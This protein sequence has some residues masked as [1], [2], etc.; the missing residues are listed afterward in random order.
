M[1]IERLELDH[2]E[3]DVDADLLE[4]LLQKL[5]H[6]QRQHL[7]GAA[8]CDDEG[9]LQRL[10]LGVAGFLDQLLRRG[11]IV[12]QLEARLAE[13]RAGWIDLALGGFCEAVHQA[14]HCLTIDREIER[15]AQADVGPGRARQ[16]AQMI[17][18]DMRRDVVDE[19]HAGRLELRHGIRRR[20]FDQVHLAGEQRVGAGQRLRHRHQHELVDLGNA[21]L[22]PI[23]RILREL[24][25][26]ARHQFRQF[27]WAGPGG[28]ARELVPILA[29][30]VVLRGAR[31][32]KPEHL[33]GKEG[34]D[35][36]GGDL[37]RG[38]VDLGV[39]C[40]RGQAGLHLCALPL[41][42]LRR[43]VVEHLVQIPDHRIGIE[44]AAVVK[45]HALAQDEA[46]LGLVLVIDFPLRGQSWHQLAGPVGD[47]H[48]PGHQGVVDRVGRE[49]IGAG[50]AVGLACRQRNIRHGDAVAHHRL[51]TRRNCGKRQRKHGETGRQSDT[52]GP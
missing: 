28:L 7:A 8:L 44:L 32:K 27:E 35:R 15:L 17:I 46:P 22:V 39:A 50:T 47:V 36:L 23:I 37:H 43:L 3:I 41:V 2:L 25:E 18:P 34:I 51:G 24:G 42:E 11:D 10:R 49:L 1:R 19:L 29:E 12:F 31:H 40:D 21:L 6:R 16:H 45:L 26:L 9:G 14:D 30:L 33:V 4:A 52:H 20:R 38:I 13:P 48:L 5:V